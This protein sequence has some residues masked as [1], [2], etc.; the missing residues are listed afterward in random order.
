MKPII[1]FVAT[2][3]VATGAA[4]GAKVMFT[5][6]AVVAD[7]TKIGVNTTGNDSS[8]ASAAAKIVQPAPGDTAKKESAVATA[9]RMA[10]ES[11]DAPRVAPTKV[12]SPAVS[13]SA[14]TAAAPAPVAAPTAADSVV[15]ASERRLAKVFT[16]ME[17]K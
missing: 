14:K 6:S 15:E 4:T 1:A 10:A 11:T 9:P 3:A 7:S 2:F 17:P 16:A 12:K 8:A 5:K 13:V